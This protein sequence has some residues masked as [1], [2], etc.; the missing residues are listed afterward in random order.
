MSNVVA[1][2][3]PTPSQQAALALYHEGVPALV[4]GLCMQGWSTDE[5]LADQLNVE[6]YAF[7]VWRKFHKEVEHAIW[8]GTKGAV[9]IVANS[10]FK[11]ATGYDVVVKE[12]QHYKGEAHQVTR[13][14]HVPADPKA[15]VAFLGLAGV[16]PDTPLPGLVKEGK[17]PMVRGADGKLRPRAPDADANDIGQKFLHAIE[18]VINRTADAVEEEDQARASAPAAAHEEVDPDAPCE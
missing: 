10:L 3:E 9:A 1:I 8:V 4:S 16:T 15:A 7:K 5:E 17:S 13:T 6:L 2:N 12:I 14:V 11:R 18:A